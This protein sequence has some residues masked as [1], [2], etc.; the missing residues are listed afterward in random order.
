MIPT[1]KRSQFYAGLILL[2]LLIAAGSVFEQRCTQD[3][4]SR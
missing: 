3:T 2:S 1:G 4:E